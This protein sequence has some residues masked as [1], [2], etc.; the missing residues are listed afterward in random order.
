MTDVESP[1]VAEEPTPDTVL[2][3]ALTGAP[4]SPA[5]AP[6]EETT[7]EPVAEAPPAVVVAPQAV[8]EPV[9]EDAP[10]VARPRRR[11]A[12]SRPAGPPT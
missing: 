4:E 12:A 7:A 9:A 2:A 10:P 8:A 1:V 6:V 11:R 5:A 3:A